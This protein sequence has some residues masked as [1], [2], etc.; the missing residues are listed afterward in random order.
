MARTNASR[1][2]IIGIDIRADG[3]AYHTGSDLPIKPEAAR[4]TLSAGPVDVV[5][6]LP[7][8]TNEMVPPTRAAPFRKNVRESFGLLH[9]RRTDV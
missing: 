1:V 4:Q 6:V 9:N 8:L 2:C 7:A 3:R 5:A